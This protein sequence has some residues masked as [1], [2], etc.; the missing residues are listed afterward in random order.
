VRGDSQEKR[1]PQDCGE[2]RG[3]SAAFEETKMSFGTDREW[4]RVGTALICTFL[5]VPGEVPLMA[6]QAAA[7]S[8]PP[9]TEAPKVRTPDQLDSLIAPIA[10]YPDP[11]LA[12]VL[13]AST[14]P[15]EIVQA[16]RWMK[17]NAK[18][19]GEKLTKAAAKEPWDA[20]VQA[21]VAFPDVLKLLDANIKW[22][23]DLGNAFLDQQSEVMDAAQRMRKKAKDGGKLQSSKEQN[24]EVKVVESKTIIEIQPSNPQVIY[25]PSYDPVVVYG[26][27]PVYAYPPVVYPYGAVAATAA[28]S[29]GVGIAMGAF[30][31]GCCGG[32]GYGWGCGWGGNNNININNNFNSRY[33]YNNINGGNR[34]Q[35]NG[36]GRNQV[37]GGPRGNNAWQHNPEHRRS[38]P[39][40]N[41]DTAQRFGGSTRDQAGRS[42]RF[43]G[44]NN[45]SDRGLNRD[46]A[47]RA[48]TRDNGAGQNRG[49]QDRGGQ[50]RGSQDKM[51]NRS[52][53]SSDRGGKSSALGGADSRSRTQAQSNRGFSSTRQSSGGGGGFGGGGGGGSRGAGASR[54]GGRRR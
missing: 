37:N 30:W 41:R 36:G 46:N 1:T 15:L 7:G 27:A 32:G 2:H 6:Q 52:I 13:A 10:L 29:F 4:L 9:K 44:R 28:I 43:D 42:E 19:T 49:A 5:L 8:Q 23:E 3:G 33:G 35:I 18:L 51:G 24:V 22:T 20:S 54:G 48:Q 21:L 39:Y 11:I 25:V 50:N 14:Y 12:Q 53:Q 17:T 45:A 31:G 16:Q 40:G 38:V 26:A 47:S 34:N